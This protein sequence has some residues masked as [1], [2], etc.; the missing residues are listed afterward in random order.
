[1]QKTL[2]RSILF[3]CVTL[4]ACTPKYTSPV[5]GPIAEVRIKLVSP[6]AFA[7]IHTYDGPGCKGPRAIGVVGGPGYLPKPEGDPE[8]GIRPNMLGS[9]GHPD[10]QVLE[11]AVPAERPLTLLYSQ[12]GPHDWQYVRS[13]KLAVTFSPRANEQ[14]EVRYQYV[15]QEEKC[16]VTVVRLSP[17]SG[18]HISYEPVG[19]L[20]RESDACRPTALP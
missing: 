19:D 12:M 3:A 17:G 2:V 7:M 13:C 14:Y 1:M 18:Q 4:A 5:S 16:S 20:I 10:S 15:A 11:V 8:R 9:S 6:E